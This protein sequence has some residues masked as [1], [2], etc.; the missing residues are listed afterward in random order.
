MCPAR[1]SSH[2]KGKPVYSVTRGETVIASYSHI[3]ILPSGVLEG[4]DKRH[5]QRQIVLAAGQWDRAEFHDRNESPPETAEQWGVA[6]ATGTTTDD[7]HHMVV[8]IHETRRSA[9]HFVN[10]SGGALVHRKVGPWTQV[11]STTKR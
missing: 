4:W 11:F 2:P 5:G 3:E 1:G 7:E 6:M 8:T 9:E 10:E